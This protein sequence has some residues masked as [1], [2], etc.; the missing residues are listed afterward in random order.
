MRRALFLLFT[1]CGVKFGSGSHS[2]ATADGG[3]ADAKAD[4]AVTGVACGRDPVTHAELC[5]G[6]SACPTLLVDPDALPGCGFVN[7]SMEI[8]CLCD[9]ELCTLGKPKS[10]A[11]AQMMLSDSN[12]LGV[13]A[14]VAEG[15]CRVAR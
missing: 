15:T 3:A 9:A 8:A 4:G 7:G 13:C 11:E 14:Q 1:A 5:S 10:C 2:M 6:V 12:V